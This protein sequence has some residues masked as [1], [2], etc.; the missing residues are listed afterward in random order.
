MSAEMV[1]EGETLL[2]VSGLQTWY[3]IRRGLMQ[4]RTGWVQAA[5][6][7]SLE[8]KPGQTLALVGESGCGKTTVGRSIL[9]LESPQKGEVYFEGRDLL[10]LAPDVMRAARQ[11]IQIIFQDPMASLDPRMR[12]RDQIAEGMRSFSIG[13]NDRERFERVGMLLERVQLDPKTMDRYPHEF[14][15]GQRQRICI[16]RALA[17]DPRLIVCDE[18]VSALDV[19]IQAQIL[20]LL[21]D[22][23]DEFGLSY[24]FI[25]HDLSVVRYLAHEVAVMYLGKI[26]ERGPTAR[27]FEAPAHPYT[28]GLLAAIPSID[29]EHRG[30]AP[31]VLGDVPSPSSPPSGCHFHTR[32]PVVMDRCRREVPDLFEIAGGGSRCLLADEDSGQT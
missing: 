18:S 15:G 19:S 7:V 27:I 10:G 12:V 28:Q 23:Q 32:C 3:P 5:T 6:D 8:I 22:L 29:P 25:T 9:R 4:R 16:A 13:A 1:A 2:R 20:N 31:A 21:R 30:A 26:V 14:S 11:R 17:V 24:L